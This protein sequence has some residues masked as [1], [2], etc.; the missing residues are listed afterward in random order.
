MT[1]RDNP[2]L[3]RLDLI[4]GRTPRRV[5]GPRPSLTL[6]RITDVAIELADAS[7]LEAVSMKRLAERLQ[8]GTMTLYTYVPDKATL[9]ALMLDRAV[10]EAALPEAV[11]DWRE[12]LRQSAEVLLAL[13]RRHPWAMQID[14]EGPP[15]APNQ[16]RYLESLLQALS[17]TGLGRKE[18][19]D[20]ALSLT[21]FVLGAA[22]TTSGLLDAER[23]S[24]LSHE[25]IRE[26]RAEAVRRVLDPAEFP[27]AREAMTASA[28]G[29]P[30]G[31]LWDSLGFAFG[32]DRFIDGIAAYAEARGGGAKA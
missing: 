1:A 21:Y 32:L 8:V 25:E 29:S 24:S 28:D 6:E 16:L 5:R 7:G 12:Q 27:L 20:T 3:V 30:P 18:M 23:T 4:W 14:I 26:R 9:L 22:K 31:G 13:Y 19:L 15:L 17:K 10:G 2:D 11:E